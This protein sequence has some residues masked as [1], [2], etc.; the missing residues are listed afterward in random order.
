M[1]D[2]PRAPGDITT[3]EEE[4]WD[5]IFENIAADTVLDGTWNQT[6]DLG[7]GV[8]S[9]ESA[10]L[11]NPYTGTFYA[12]GNRIYPASRT[13]GT[14][15]AIGKQG[16]AY[17]NFAACGK[18]IRQ[19]ILLNEDGSELCD[20]EDCPPCCKKAADPQCCGTTPLR[21]DD[22]S[23]ITGVSGTVTVRF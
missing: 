4:L 19:V 15:Y 22:G 18:A 1:W 11:V 9:I 3:P 12:A 2:H 20:L 8:H 5:D 7:G 17:Y 10:Y 23:I 13:G 16:S 14:P 21:A 6:M